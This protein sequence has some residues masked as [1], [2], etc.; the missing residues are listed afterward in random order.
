MCLVPSPNRQFSRRGVSGT[1]TNRQ[2]SRRDVSGTVT[3]QAVQLSWCVWYR[4]LTG[5]S[6][7]VMCLVPSL[8]D[9]SAVVM[10]LVP[11]YKRQFPDTKSVHFRSDILQAFHGDEQTHRPIEQTHRPI[12]KTYRQIEQTHRPVEQTHCPK[13]DTPANQTD[14]PGNRRDTLQLQ[15]FKTPPVLKYLCSYLSKR[16]QAPL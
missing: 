15:K 13:E 9:N 7:V 4:H 11:S 8:T 14:T 5:S 1:V 16:S 6:A 10:C 2:F 12:E 3:W